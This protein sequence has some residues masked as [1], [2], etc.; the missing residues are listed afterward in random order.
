[1]DEPLDRVTKK[2]GEKTQITKISNERGTM[3][4]GPVDIQ[5]I[6]K[7]YCGQLY[8]HKFNDLDKMEQFLE[9]R[10]LPK[11]IQGEISHLNRPILGLP[12]WRSG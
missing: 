4:T 10:S 2:K 7:E 1:M 9:R 11:F 8:V 3:A 12:W 5:R 6:I